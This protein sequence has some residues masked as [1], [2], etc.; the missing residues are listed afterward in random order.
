MDAPP[1]GVMGEDVLCL[2]KVGPLTLLRNKNNRQPLNLGL[3]FLSIK[4]R[5]LS[6]VNTE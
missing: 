1:L 5:F 4:S 2:A 3:P 6:E